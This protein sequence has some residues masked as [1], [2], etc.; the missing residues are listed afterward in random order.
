MSTDIVAGADRAGIF[1][2]V[3]H[4]RFRPLWTA[5][6]LSGVAYM[7]ALTACGWV[8]FD[9]HH[10]S[11]TVGLVVF[12]SFLPSLIITPFAGVFADR[13]DRRTMLLTMNAIGLLST[14]G[15]AW[16][17]WAGDQSA[18]PL[19]AVSFVLGA[20][21]SS[22]T[23][24]EQA[25]LGSLVPARDLLN[26]VSLLQA[27]LN[28][29]RL[30]GPLLAAPLLH[31]GGGF[32]AF[33]VAAALFALAFWAIWVLGE[34]PH[35]RSGSDHNPLVQFAQG[36]SYV[37]HAPAVCSVITLVVLHCAFTMGY[38]AALPRRASDV[39][40]ATG[41][42][43]SLLMM[44]MGGGSLVGAFLLA[45]FARRVHCGYLFFATSILSGL[46][47]VPLGYAV[48][49]PGALLAAAAV[50]LT[51]SIF[52]ALARTLLQI[53]TPDPVRGRVLG[54]YWG[55][56][57]GVMAVSNLATGRLAD[58]LGA[59]PMLALPGLAFGAVTVLT[60]CAPTLRQI[61]GRRL[62]TTAVPSA[63]GRL[64]PRVG[65]VDATD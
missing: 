6:I 40:G 51:Q 57:G 54:L 25:M 52:I 43:Y 59:G 61:Y 62:A 30:L 47:L 5:S 15:L 60:L 48:S 64:R 34:V 44:A 36:A 42:A 31:V 46:T 13:Y 27:N 29:A 33:L 17:A 16:V 18:W 55:S 14:L 39:L 38:D 45:G 12:A 53:A 41:T 10:H 37:F 26:A 28:G 50:G 2:A 9:L 49:W 35:Q 8:A 65:R 21:R 3:Q 56:T 1:S 23:P 58:G 20:S 7:T 32:G 19:V 63:I 22:S 24:M 11:S 4:K